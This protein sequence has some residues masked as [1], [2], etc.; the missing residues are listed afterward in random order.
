VSE[1]FGT[2]IM[3]D[4]NFLTVHVDKIK[5]KIFKLC[6]VVRNSLAAKLCNLKKFDNKYLFRGYNG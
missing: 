4:T 5:D 2:C 1:L 3:F 6:L